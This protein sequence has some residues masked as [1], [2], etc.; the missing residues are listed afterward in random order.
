MPGLREIRES[1]LMSYIND[2][3]DDVEFCLLYDENKSFNPDFPY[4]I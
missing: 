2:E 3:I 4:W 1:I